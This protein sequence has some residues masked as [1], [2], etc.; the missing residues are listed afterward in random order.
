M[1][2]LRSDGVAWVLYWPNQSV[3]HLRPP[4]LDL[5]FPISK[6]TIQLLIKDARD[7]L[8]RLLAFEKKIADNSHLP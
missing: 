4:P 8:P 5:P 7:A 3:L 6:V 2:E 1:S